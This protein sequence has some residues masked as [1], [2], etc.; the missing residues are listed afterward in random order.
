[1]A[2]KFLIAPIKS[3]L[4]TDVPSWLT[5]EDSLSRL[6]NAYIYKGK[7]RKRFGS[8]LLGGSQETSRLRLVVGQTDGSGNITVTVPGAKFN[9]GQM[10]S[11]G[12]EIF[13]VSSL[14]NP[15]TLKTTGV[16]TVHT[17]DTTTG[18]LILNTPFLNEDVYFYPA[19]PVMQITHYES[20]S[21]PNN[22]PAYAFDTQFAYKYDSGWERSGTVVF[23]GTDTNGFS[24]TNWLGSSLSDTALYV[25]NFN[26]TVGTPA[27]GDDPLYSFD[28]SSWAEFRPVFKVTSPNTVTGYVS[29][30][31]IIV[32][33]NGRL[34]LFNTVEN[35]SGTNYSYQ[36]RCRY[37][38][39]GSPHCPATGTPPTTSYSAWLEP[40]QSWTGS[41][42][43]EAT[44]GGAGWLD[45]ATEEE[46]I[47]VG[48]INDRLIVY[49]ERSTWELVK[50]GNHIQPFSWQ[51]LNTE[52][53]SESQFSTVV[54]DKAVLTLSS[55][56]VHACNGVNVDKVDSAIEGEEKVFSVKNT[57]DGRSRVVGI[58]DYFEKMVYWS[59]TST[60]YDSNSPKYPNKLIIYNLS[61]NSW[62]TADDCITAFGYDEDLDGK[63]WS[64]RQILAGNQQGFVYKLDQDTYVNAHSMYITDMS[65][66]GSTT[67]TLT[68]VDHTLSTGNY[69]NIEGYSGVS[70][71]GTDNFKV[72]TVTSDTVSIEVTSFSGTY[73]GGG[74]VSRVSKIDILSKQWNP[75]S[76]K[77]SDVYI[78][79][80]N[81]CVKKTTSGKIIVDYR[82][83][84]TEISMIDEGS[85]SSSSLGSNVL[86]TTPYSLAP[87]E[88]LKER[89]WHSVYFQTFGECVQIRIYL[90]DSQ[91]E[92][93]DISGSDLTIEAMMLYTTPISEEL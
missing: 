75:Y 55:N 5:P 19:D 13:T 80:I 67:L 33:F 91:M 71:T 9:V 7:I 35:L 38:W 11:V 24:T 92:D 76:K 59:F 49:F 41:A 93:E 2:D 8:T 12:T 22:N 65:F 79:H 14:G 18:Q 50:T 70:I 16:T 85:S 15:V 39:D 69:I 36:N 58:R 6:N 74:I 47:S 37:S 44:Y 88:S 72:T 48:F 32:K 73:T 89:L 25:T 81:F 20:G 90:N 56:G 57:N 23:Q 84:S 21:N 51:K 54:F 4:I 3:G 78:S 30:C 46:I 26:V 60:T 27:A 77:G 62:A 40:E 52:I 29:S 66:D 87:L 34:L 82:P 63:T 17:F 31:R 86:E 45:A 28:G 61:S 68:I 10:F 53:G 43:S 64:P 83:S 1:M 42:S